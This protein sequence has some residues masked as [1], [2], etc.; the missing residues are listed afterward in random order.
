[1]NCDRYVMGIDCGSTMIKAAIYDESG[2][3]IAVAGEKVMTFS[4]FSGWMENDAE[5]LWNTV[6]RVVRATLESV[7]INPADIVC[8]ACTGYGN[9]LY[10]TD[11]QGCP[12][13]NGII[14]SDVRAKNF[15]EQWNSDGTSAA[16]RN[17]TMQ[18]MW[19]GQPPPLIRWLHENEPESLVRARWYFACKDYIRFRMTGEAFFELSDA[20][21]SS[22]VNVASGQYD[23]EIFN[24][25]DIARWKDLFPPLKRSTDLCGSVSFEAASRTGLKKGTPV[26][27]GMFD[28]DACSLAVGMT[29]E[30]QLAMVA[31]TWGNNLALS[32][33]PSDSDH[34]F[35]TSR[36]CVEPFY[37]L[38]EGSP[39]SANNFDWWV[40]QFYEN[41]R[42][43]FSKNIASPKTINL[44]SEC[45]KLAQQVPLE[46]DGPVFLPYLYGSPV[47]ADAKG[48]LFGL[49][50][51][52]SQSSV[53]RA[54]LEGIVFGHRWHVE[55]LLK[56]RSMSQTIRLTGGAVKSPFWTQIFADLF[57]TRIEVP[58]GTEFGTG[59]AS[60][61][62]AVAAGLHENYEEACQYR[63]HIG[64]VYEPDP[65]TASVY[66]KKYQRFK[67]LIDIFN[68]RWS[69]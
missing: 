68:G 61:C 50:G 21:G 41:N 69:L 8:L 46:E 65:D 6:C 25:W 55:R 52:Q 13:R 31:G 32:L 12:I 34:V 59:G 29:D 18:E 33:D 60:L 23:D 43:L 57:Q 38:L 4:S 49:D 3:E 7:R 67:N 66:E 40:T 26:A 24:A 35:M 56:K 16:I 30:T 63:V 39:T 62:A 53:L 19:P 54:V 22:M 5:E 64:R 42:S 44:Y 47:H 20:S 45:A 10:L 58:E 17:R 14:S 27:A 1:M 28:I 51:R 15:T 2:K 36:Y 48:I 9:G 37:L 11:E